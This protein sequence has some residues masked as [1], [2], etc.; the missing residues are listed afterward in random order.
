MHTLDGHHEQ[1]ACWAFFGG[2]NATFYVTFML[3]FLVLEEFLIQKKGGLP[4]ER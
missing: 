3:H 4:W 2:S 1:D